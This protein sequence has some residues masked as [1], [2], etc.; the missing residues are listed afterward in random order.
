[1]LLP[2]YSPPLEK[3]NV[4]VEGNNSLTNVSVKFVQHVSLEYLNLS[5]VY[6][7]C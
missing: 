6:Q 5:N 1:M 3:V 7:S 4:Q 2:A